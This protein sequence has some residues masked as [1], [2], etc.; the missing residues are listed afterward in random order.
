[1]AQINTQS[2]IGVIGAG[3]MGRGIA[4]VASKAGHKVLL[5]DQDGEA[6]KNSLVITGKDLAKLV[7]KGKIE[8]SKRTQA[9]ELI[10]PC[11]EFDNLASCDIVIEAIVENLQIKK[12]I[13]A[14][15]Q[16]LNK[17]MIIASN[18]SSISISSL[19]NGLDKPE[20]ILGIH[21]FNP[22][23]I[24]KLVEII[25]GLQTDEVIRQEV[26]DLVAS[27]GKV[28]VL[29]KSSPG[30][31]VNR[32]ARPFYAESMRLVEEGVSDFASLDESLKNNGSFRMG[33][34]ELMDLI[35]NDT[36][37]S[38][39]KSM[40]D[41]YYSDP[42]FKPSVLQ[43][44]YVCA[45]LLGRKA[46]RGFYDYKEGS[47]VVSANYIKPQLAIDASQEEIVV[48]GDLGIGSHLLDLFKQTNIIITR[49]AKSEIFSLSGYIEYNDI[50]LYIANGKMATEFSKTDNLHNIVQLDICLDFRATKSLTI[51]PSLLAS[52]ECQTKIASLFQIIDKKTICIKDS[53][54]MVTLR[55]IA[56]LANEA[57]STVTSQVC[58]Q[59]SADE[60][61]KYGVNYKRGPFEW[62]DYLGNDYILNTLNELEDFYKD[63]RYRA[64]RGLIHNH[65]TKEKYGQ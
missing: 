22:A 41:S 49:H 5:Y 36:N 63:G 65:Y 38:V 53:P 11:F 56:M 10:V 16:Q 17:E 25:Y 28:C 44:E 43:Y 2:V 61:M 59:K 32:I 51:A 54:A 8:E 21:F 52:K 39:T 37:Y 57:S 23:P 20:N 24:M 27:W 18:T 12:E 35:G 62:I 29:V 33:P 46:S 58:D 30:F 47:D 7:A 40:Y 31:I 34:F 13:F 50:I 45:G 48:Y 15:L 14:K 1:M 60:A 55:T 19:A 6:V 4:Q 9:L 3:I 64:D 42:R 26:Y